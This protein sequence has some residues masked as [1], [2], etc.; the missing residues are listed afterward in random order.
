MDPTNETTTGPWRAGAFVAPKRRGLRGR[1]TQ[2]ARRAVAFRR[3]D[4]ARNREA[5]GRCSRDVFFWSYKFGCVLEYVFCFVLW[6]GREV[7]KS[8]TPQELFRGRYC[9]GLHQSLEPAAKD[10]R[11]RRL[12]PMEVGLW[13]W[14]SWKTPK[15][16]VTCGVFI[17]F[18]YGNMVWDRKGWQA[19]KRLMNLLGRLVQV[20][21][22]RLLQ[23]EL[24]G[25]SEVV[26]QTEVLLERRH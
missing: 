13:S 15:K 24:F 20:Q 12:G 17:W 23:Q 19:F 10:P 1:P 16:H 11:P 26:F 4:P 14:C 22:L 6:R 18:S 5:L 7:I 9:I 3:G 2:A 21:L 8:E 25:S